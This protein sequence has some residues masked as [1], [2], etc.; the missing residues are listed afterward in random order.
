M[1]RSNQSC[2]AIFATFQFHG[3]GRSRRFYSDKTAA[4]RCCDCCML[5]AEHADPECLVA[6]CRSPGSMLSAELIISTGPCPS[7]LWAPLGRLK[8]E[9]PR[10]ELTP[11]GGCAESVVTGRHGI[12]TSGSI[13]HVRNRVLYLLSFLCHKRT[14]HS[15]VT[16]HA[17]HMYT[18]A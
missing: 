12:V 11:P 15:F 4:L 9:T 16:L 2:F 8:A 1:Y 17:S 18:I 5:C 3:S 14:S 7:S 13:L 10:S 6:S